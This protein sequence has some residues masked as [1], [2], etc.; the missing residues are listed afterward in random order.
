MNLD[1]VAVSQTGSPAASASTV[2]DDDDAEVEAEAE[3]AASPAMTVD[4]VGPA[5]H[6]VGMVDV[7]IGY[8]KMSCSSMR[9]RY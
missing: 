5:Q 2:D 7:Q 3:E 6:W 4:I 1:L 8:Q 9:F